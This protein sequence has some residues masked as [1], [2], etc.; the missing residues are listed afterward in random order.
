MQKLKI[1][2]VVGATAAVAFALLG[3]AGPVMAAST[4]TTATTTTAMYSGGWDAA[5]AQAHGFQL[6]TINGQTVS[7]PV[8]AAA[9]QLVSSSNSLSSSAIKP[10]NTVTGNCGSSTVTTIYEG[11]GRV[12]VLTSY[13]V[14]LPSV[15]QSWYVTLTSVGGAFLD[16]MNFSG[17]NGST[18]WVG[19]PQTSPA[20]TIAEQGGDAQVTFGSFAILDDGDVCFSGGPIDWW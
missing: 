17:L 16:E 13:I 7:V 9:K 5:V 10:D 8:T 18:H 4:S 3:A 15:D 2:V 12:K 6:E 20:S 11:S 14:R 19:A 1:R